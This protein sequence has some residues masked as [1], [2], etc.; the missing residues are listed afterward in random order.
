MK[1]K[2]AD[3]SGISLDWAVTKCLGLEDETL[4]PVTWLETA[5]PS[6][7]YDYSTDWSLGGPLIER[8]GISIRLWIDDG[9]CAHNEPEGSEENGCGYVGTSGG[10]S[11]IA[12]MRCYVASKM[13]DEIEIPDELLEN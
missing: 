12:A 2:T 1:I 4:D 8:E 11:L 13:G 9:W 3:L 10:T 6:R 7:C 5:Y